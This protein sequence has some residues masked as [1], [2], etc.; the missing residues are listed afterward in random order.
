[1][2]KVM[3]GILILIPVL[4]LLILAAVSK[5]ISVAAWI[6][7]DDFTIYEKG[8]KTPAESL[9]LELSDVSST[10]DFKSYFDIDIMP[11]R[12]NR[13]TVEWR[14]SEDME[15]LDEAYGASYERYLQQLAAHNAYL[16]KIDEINTA[17][18]RLRLDESIPTSERRE[19]IKALEDEKAALKEPEISYVKAPAAMVDDGGN[20]VASNSTGKFSVASF[21]RFTVVVQVEN[22]SKSFVVSVVGYDVENVSIVNLPGQDSNVLNVGESKRVEAKYEPVDSIVSRTKWHSS[23]TNVATV[24][25]NGVITGVN[26]GKAIITVEANKYTAEDVFVESGAYEIEV[27]ASGI[28]SKFGSEI[29]TSK[30]SVKLDDIGLKSADIIGDVEGGTRDGNIITISANQAVIPTAR[31]KFTVRKCAPQA[32]KILHSDLF[33]ANGGYVFAV[34]GLP[35]ALEARWADDL[36]TG[37]PDGVVWTSSN[38]DIASV[39]NGVVNASASGRIVITASRNGHVA[40]LDLDTRVKVTSVQLRNSKE[41]LAIGLARETVFATYK[42]VNVADGNMMEVND[43]FMTI[44]G[45]PTKRDGESEE[46]YA[47]R[48]AEFYDNYKFEVISNAECAYFADDPASV[49]PADKRQANR[50]ILIP[51]AF[52]SGRKSLVVKVSAK[53]PKYDSVEISTTV[54]I[55]VV[56]GVEVS[57]IAEFRAAAQQQKEYA[58]AKDNVILPELTLDRKSVV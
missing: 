56:Y 8:T 36:A 14:I 49:V 43:I 3:I 54:T 52:R 45:E 17:I 55:N 1:M 44:V 5:I 53:Y 41:N 27:K 15:C 22:I 6:A 58:L 30:S 12:A 21:C 18:E 46:A 10:L 38:D 26:A 2:K 29:T 37:T 32:I 16:L 40:T 7:V 28:S 23:N 25:G 13:Y 19:R 34:S 20:E 50:L 39:E 51:T 9:V 48:L 47:E 4:I 33:D 42:F 11:E 35:L 57:N 24:D 31:G